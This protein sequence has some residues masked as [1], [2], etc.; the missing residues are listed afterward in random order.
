MP[1]LAI[2]G[3]R[4][5]ASVEDGALVVVIHDCGVGIVRRETIEVTASCVRVPSA[6]AS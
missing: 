4:L 5:E 3:T 1:T 2:I 6:S